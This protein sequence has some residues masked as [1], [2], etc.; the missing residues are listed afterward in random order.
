VLEL[1]RAGRL[2]LTDALRLGTAGTAEAG[3][4]TLGDFMGWNGL[5]YGYLLHSH[6]KSPF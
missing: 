6:G 1:L 5:P 4:A 3:D 2:Q